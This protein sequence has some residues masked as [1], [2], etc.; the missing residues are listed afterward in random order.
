MAGT[1]SPT[2]QPTREAGLITPRMATGH[3]SSPPPRASPG[4]ACAANGRTGAPPPPRPGWSSTMGRCWRARLPSLGSV[5]WSV[6]AH[7]RRC[8]PAAGCGASHDLFLS[9]PALASLARDRLPT[10]AE[11]P[12]QGASVCPFPGPSQK[13]ILTVCRRRQE[14]PRKA[15]RF[16]EAAS[17]E[18]RIGARLT[19]SASLH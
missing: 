9:C 16:H 3:F 11:W 10:L 14:G 1:R 13:R 6:R 2:A 8:A 5:S 15:L 17:R 7:G 18:T 12:A 4:R 19:A